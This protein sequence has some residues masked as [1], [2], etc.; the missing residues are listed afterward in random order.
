MP[1][2]HKQV[3]EY[4]ARQ[5]PTLRRM[6]YGSHHEIQGLSDTARVLKSASAAYERD[7]EQVGAAILKVWNDKIL[8]EPER[9]V[10]TAQLAR[11]KLEQ[12]SSFYDHTIVAAHDELQSLEASL[13]KTWQPPSSAG[14]AM[15]DG[16]LRK[17][18]S[19]L[20]PTDR[21]AAVRQDPELRAAAARGHHQLS[22]LTADLHKTIRREH[23]AS[24]EPDLAARV[25]DLN[26]AY[27]GAL[28]ATQSLM[29]DFGQ[30]TDFETAKALEATS[31]A[32]V[33]A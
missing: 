9:V 29:D 25:D 31:S 17:Y 1:I 10:R 8:S 6:R 33:I 12:A 32:S 28:K 21:L 26:A 18:L 5:A 20:S 16:E 14:Q 11:R 7:S 27:V 3:N 24:V 19:G 15:H 13:S 23:A 30:I 2:S 4:S 22:G